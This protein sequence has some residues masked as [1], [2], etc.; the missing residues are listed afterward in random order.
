MAGSGLDSSLGVAVETG[1]YGTFQIPNRFMEFDSESLSRN[2]DYLQSSGLRRGQ[3]GNPV[4]RHRQTTRRPG[5]GLSLK[6][7]NKGFLPFLHLL[8]GDANAPVQQGVT[9]AYLTTIAVGLTKPTAKSLTVQIAKEPAEGTVEVFSYLGCMISAINFACD[10]SGDL[11]CDID[12]TARDEV[13]TEAL[14]TPSYATGIESR[15]FTEGDVLVDDVSATA[16][17]Q[18]VNIG[19]PIPMKDDRFGLGRGALRARP[20]VNDK[21]VPTLSLGAEFTNDDLLDLWTGD[22]PHKLT[23]EFVGPII[24]S[25]YAELIRFTFYSCKLTGS[26]PNVGGPDVLTQEVPIEVFSNGVDPLVTIEYMS[27]DTAL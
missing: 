17:I 15:D 23:V 10:L 7:P 19:I 13:L 12:L 25:T 5:G 8:N 27:T 1:G 20:I 6:V 11:T 9:T 24:A 4:G 26:T 2:P 22:E 14:A 3:L 21:I 18:S 16:L